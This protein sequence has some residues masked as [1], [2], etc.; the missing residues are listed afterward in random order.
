VLSVWVAVT[1]TVVSTGC[2]TIN[3]RVTEAVME[4]GQAETWH[5][6][7]GSRSHYGL[8][9]ATIEKVPFEGSVHTANVSVRYQR[10]LRDQARCIADMTAGLLD[11]VQDHIGV[12]ITTGSSIQLLR[13]DQTPQNFDIDL[14]VEPNEFP[15]PL[16]V[17]A[18]DETCISILA[19]NRGYPYLLVH[20]L[21]ETSL[22]S[23]RAGGVLPDLSWGTLGLN[24]HVNNY[25]RWFRDGLANYAGFVAYE[26]FAEELDRSGNAPFRDALLH[27]RPFSSLAQVR[28]KLFSWRQS[29]RARYGRANYNAALGL[30]LLIRAQFGQEAI[31]QIVEAVGRRHYVDGR[32]LIEI[33]NQVLETDLKTLVSDF[34]FP[35]IGAVLERMTP[36]MAL[37]NGVEVEEGLLVKSV[38][39]DGLGQVAGLKDNDVIVAVGAAPV[40]NHLDFELALYPFRQNASVPL[41]IHR[42]DAGTL[43]LQLPLRRNEEPPD[44][45]PTPG[46]R[47]KP[48]KKG[49]TE[50]TGS[51]PFFLF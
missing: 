26:A 46:K 13:F 6:H 38:C 39:Q 2:R 51:F 8:S 40:T 25:T 12:T 19:Q 36:A 1:M 10:G 5:V 47:R 18:G 34:E 45:T 14:S 24:A 50:Y 44:Q 22:A 20:E 3:K 33:A 32:D 48:L 4:K 23:P 41:T 15:L 30:F 27:T 9:D 37:N 29:S 11:H 35:D 21:V 28:T 31:R 42:V 43:T 17:R 49:R 7:Y 16:F